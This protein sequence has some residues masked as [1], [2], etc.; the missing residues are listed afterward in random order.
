MSDALDDAA[1]LQRI[2][3]ATEDGRRLLAPAAI[4]ARIPTEPGADC[5]F[6]ADRN[7]ANDQVSATPLWLRRQRGRLIKTCSTGA[8]RQRLM[9]DRADRPPPSRRARRCIRRTLSC[10][11]ANANAALAIADID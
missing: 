7:R 10:G 2:D 1:L 4:A 11:F 5:L 8:R 9:P 6:L 3:G